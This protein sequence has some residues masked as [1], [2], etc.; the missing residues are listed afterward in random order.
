MSYSNPLDKKISQ[1]LAAANDYLA[2]EQS[3]PSSSTVGDEG[4]VLVGNTLGK[5]EVVVVAHSAVDIKN[6][7]TFTVKLQESSDD[8]DSDAYADIQGGTFISVSGGSGTTYSAGEVIGRYTINNGDEK[9]IKCYLDG[10]ASDTGTIDVF[11][12]RNA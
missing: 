6:G 10:G 7:S 8:A 1:P 4:S 2:S 5:L 12:S 3:I 9:Y 11:V